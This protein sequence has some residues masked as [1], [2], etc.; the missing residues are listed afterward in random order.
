MNTFTMA[1]GCLEHL[2]SIKEFFVTPP[3]ASGFASV[4]RRLLA[5]RYNLLIRPDASVIEIGC[6]MGELLNYLDAKRKIGLDLSPEQIARGK[7]QFPH[8]D[9]R[10][11]AG[12]TAILPEGPFDVI[13]LSDVLN[14]AADVEVLL[15]RLHAL[16]HQ[17]TRLLINVYNTIWRPLL[18]CAR[19][20][21][22]AAEQPAS[23][24]L[25]KQD[26]INLCSL[27]DW[28]VFKSFGA[29]LVP[30]PLGPV[31]GILN[32]WIAPLVEWLCLSTFLIGRRG[33]LP[34]RSAKGVSVKYRPSNRTCAEARRGN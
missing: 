25:S 18:G 7:D 22:W 8:L 3:R 9:L 31:S 27:A 2:E 26:V 16:S 14:Y 6:G 28:G 32:R 11:G 13:I 33:D 5:H 21:G 30:L 29:I 20:L 17:G 15:R 23:N 12:E 1:P 24:W 10:V 19:R 34:R 4:Y